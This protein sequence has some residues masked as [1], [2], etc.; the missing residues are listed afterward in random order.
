VGAVVVGHVLGVIVAH[1]RAI[2]LLPR[3]KA[4]IGQLPML[5]LMIG[6]TMTGLWLLFSS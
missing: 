3:R 4:V 2:K 1:N 6:Y 5:V